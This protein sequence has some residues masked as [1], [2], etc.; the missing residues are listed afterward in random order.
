METIWGLAAWSG[1]SGLVVRVV[2]PS[3]RRVHHTMSGGV[4]ARVTTVTNTTN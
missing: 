2:Q 4:R 3:P 1:G